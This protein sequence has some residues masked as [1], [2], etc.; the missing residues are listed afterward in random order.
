VFKVELSSGKIAETIAQETGA[1]VLEFNAVH[2]VSME[3][4]KAGVTYVTLMRKN[5]LALKEALL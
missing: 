3:D 1:K 5:V 4:F 2:N